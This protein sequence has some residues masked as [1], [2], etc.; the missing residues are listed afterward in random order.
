MRVV[1]IG[2][3][4]A[5]VLCALRVARLGGANVDVTL[6]NARADFVERVRL[7]E[8][9]AGA[10]DEATSVRALLEGTSVK[11]AIGWV[12]HIDLGARTVRVAERVWH[13]DRLVIAVGSQD[14]LERVPGAR[15]HAMSLEGDSVLANAARLR[16]LSERGGRV[17]VL[18]AGLTGIE[19]AT[20]LAQTYR[21]LH[22]EIVARGSVGAGLSRAAQ[23]HVRRTLENDRVRIHEYVRVRRIERDRLLTEGG[24]LAFDA[25]VWA[26]GFVAP[27]LARDAGLSVN[28][29]RQA[30]VDAQ[31]RAIGHPEVYVIGDAAKQEGELGENVPMGCKSALPMAT[32]AA[33]AI[34]AEVRGRVPRKPFVFRAPLYCV[35][36]GRHDGIVQLRPD[37]GPNAPHVHGA[38]AA[39]IKAWIVKGTL[40][41]LRFER[42]RALSFSGT[43]ALALPAD[44]SQDG[45]HG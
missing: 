32:F 7:H 1:V 21:G 24:E 12:E 27:H 36:L 45:A 40:F 25:C 30:W 17:V 38:L 5:G 34:A 22:L 29:S 39:R 44:A 4:Y 35:S 13:W 20:E 11:L 16:A 10:H 26:A 28:A 2:G 23:R 31:L 19:I 9:A 8:H 15:E 3:G 37:A 41:T 33:D 43:R 14:D 6:V 42:W 18:G